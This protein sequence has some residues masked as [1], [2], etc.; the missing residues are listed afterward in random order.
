MARQTRLNY[1]A[2]TEVSYSNTGYRLVEAALERKGLSTSAISSA[3]LADRSM[4]PSMHLTSG[5]MPSPVSSRAIGTTAQMAALGG[6]P[7]YLR[8]RQ[9]DGSAESLANWL[10]ALLAGEGAFAGVLEKL[11]RPA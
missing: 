4:L 2:G 11:S 8:I 9:L 5:T 7:A 6:R 1:E 3:I 10:R